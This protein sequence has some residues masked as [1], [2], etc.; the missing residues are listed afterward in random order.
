ME[1]TPARLRTSDTER[2]QAAE[3]LRAAM[4]E[5]RLDMVEGE[6]RLASAY[7]AKYRDEL[8]SLTAD[9]PGGG[10]HA[11]ARTPRARA[12]TRRSLRRHASFIMILAGVL[13]GLWI[14][15]GSGFFWPAIPLTFLVVGLV[16]HAA[17]GRW[18]PEYTFGHH[19]GR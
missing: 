17:H 13:T 14:I 8:A 9:L 3:I 12:A 10:R 1:T 16:K 15:S 19:H 4:A 11:L 7:A 18:R 6:E 5:G 2:E